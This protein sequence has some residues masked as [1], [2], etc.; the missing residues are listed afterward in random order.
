M[1]MYIQSEHVEPRSSCKYSNWALKSL[2]LD[3]S[4]QNPELQSLTKSLI[5]TVRFCQFLKHLQII[6]DADGTFSCSQYAVCQGGIYQIQTCPTG[7]YFDQIA[8]KYFNEHDYNKTYM[9]FRT[10]VQTQPSSVWDIVDRLHLLDH[11]ATFFAFDVNYALDL[12]S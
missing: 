5:F 6:Y 4:T 12:F 8:C 2:S 7:E 3:Q 9:N 11:E 10:G 1:L